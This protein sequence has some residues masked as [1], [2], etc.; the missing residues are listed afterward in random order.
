MTLEQVTKEA[1]TLPSIMRAELAEIMVESL[2]NDV[3]EDIQK[4]W[5]EV[6]KRRRDEVRN[7]TSIPIPSKI[8]FAK[9]EQKLKNA[10]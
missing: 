2:A 9:L 1:L 8:V 7:G 5:L 10:I 4:L 3:D 6:A